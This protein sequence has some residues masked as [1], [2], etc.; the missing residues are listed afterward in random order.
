HDQRRRGTRPFAWRDQCNCAQHSQSVEKPDQ[1]FS[2]VL[3]FIEPG[4]SRFVSH[5]KH[6]VVS[7]FA[8]FINRPGGGGA[9]KNY[10]QCRYLCAATFQKKRDDQSEQSH[11]QTVDWQRID[12][13]VDI[14][15]LAQVAQNRVKHEFSNANSHFNFSVTESRLFATSVC[16]PSTEQIFSNRQ[17]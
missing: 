8:K 11:R 12:Q 9:D 17:W 16:L 14:F 4:L 2:A 15:R 3:M 1:I 6:A 13:D 7:L 5:R 10:D